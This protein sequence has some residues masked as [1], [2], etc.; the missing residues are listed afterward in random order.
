[1]T[2]AP[3]FDGRYRQSSV[4]SFSSTTTLLG[5]E[6]LK[7]GDCQY[8]FEL[9]GMY[10]PLPEPFS[11]TAAAAAAAVEEEEEWSREH[12]MA[13]LS[14]DLESLRDVEELV[15]EEAVPYLKPAQ[16]HLTDD[17]RS[18][19]FRRWSASYSFVL[20]GRRRR[21]RLPLPSRSALWNLMEFLGV[22][23]ESP[24]RLFERRRRNRRGCGGDL[25]DVFWP[26]VVLW[27]VVNGLTRM[28]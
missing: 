24:L 1:M 3:S 28:L 8:N 11:F 2:S 17:S 4:S 20:R 21:I 14:V 27:L 9:D 16:D 6:N 12:K 10:D 22:V 18:Q 23:D 25:L 7:E 19:I 5:G 15:D 13:S 26:A